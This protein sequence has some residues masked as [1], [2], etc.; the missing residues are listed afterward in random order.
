MCPWGIETLKRATSYI[1]CEDGRIPQDAFVPSLV[2][3]YL[4]LLVEEL[5]AGHSFQLTVQ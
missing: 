4:E 1:Y 3:V 5:L 2:M